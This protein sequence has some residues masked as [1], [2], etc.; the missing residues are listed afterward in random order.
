MSVPAAPDAALLDTFAER[1]RAVDGEV[2]TAA[3]VAAARDHITALC[4]EAGGG[5]VATEEAAPYAPP[6]A[7]R[8]AEPE[9]I[10]RA[11]CGISV[12]RL[13][14]AETGSV[15]LAPAS[16]QDRLI[17]V[18]PPLHV[19]VLH[20]AVLYASLDDA[21]AEMRTLM[22]AGAYAS[23]VTGPSRTADIERV[24]T[25]GAHGPATVHVLL[26]AEPL[27]DA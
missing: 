14:V 8:A 18:L 1:L 22:E 6:D 26:M 12:A 7:G 10:A 16:R 4:T 24:I 25:V 19:V 23:L 13:G 5:V 11:A 9:S 27:R 21:A 15:L 2:A 3:G 17:A 20:N